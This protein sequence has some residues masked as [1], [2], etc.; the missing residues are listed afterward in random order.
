MSVKY[1]LTKYQDDFINSDNRIVSIVGAKG[2]SK[3]WCGARFA[4]VQ[5]VKQPKSQGL[6][7][8]NSRQQIIDIYEQDIRPLLEELDWTF[9]FNYQA[10][11]LTIYGSVIHLRSAD[12]DAV[13]KIES[14]TYSW[15]WADE[16]SY[17]DPETL[18]TFFSR[19]RKGKK[20]ARITSMPD[21]PDHTMYAFL[22]RIVK[23]FDGSLYE[24]GLLDNPDK[25]FVEDYVK[26]LKATYSG[27]QLDRFLYGKRVSLEGE[28]LFR[29]ESDMRGEYKY[30]PNVDLLLC[31]D[32]NVEYRAVSAW[33]KQGYDEKGREI[34]ACVKSWQLKEATVREDAIALCKHLSNHKSIIY[35]QGDA[36]GENRSASA[37]ISMWKMIRDVFYDYFPDVRP[38]VP[39]KNP[40]VKDTIQCVNWALTEGLVYFD[41]DERNVYMSLQAVKADKYGEISKAMDYSNNT[42]ARSHEADTARYA[43][44]HYYQYVWAGKKGGIF[45]V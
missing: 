16:A 15:G 40:P 1:T 19:I 8:A 41:R 6:I 12:P 36:S 24:I 27:A 33:Q 43:I 23:D 44:W 4:L 28:G 25:Q 17:Y 30:D 42:S 38:V 37:T 26:I 21:E 18:K 35:L 2:S 22:E 9:S 5:S 11:K 31:W 45:I 3:T 29:V 14:I 34:I 39:S 32:F 7:M 20:L 10:L 13:K